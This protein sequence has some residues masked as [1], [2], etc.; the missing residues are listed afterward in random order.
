[1]AASRRRNSGLSDSAALRL[2]PLLDA[3]LEDAP[4]GERI[5][6][7]P[8]ELPHR[9]Q[10]PRDIEVSGL[11]SAA[12]AYG[13]ADPSSPK[14]EALLGRMGRSPA[15]FVTTWTSRELGNCS[16]RLC[17]DLTLEQTSLYC[18]WVW[19]RHFAKRGRSKTCSRNALRALRLSTARFLDLPRSFETSP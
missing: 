2:R 17:I 9:Y 18:F 5:A 19:E 6:F 11:L 16:N 14:V 15:E 7:D 1:M 4:M 3:F 10:N 8:V 12:L 13:R